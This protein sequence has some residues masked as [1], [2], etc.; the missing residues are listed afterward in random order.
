[1]NTESPYKPPEAD[2]S[3]G[4]SDSGDLMRAFIGTKNTDYYLDAFDKIES[5]AGRRWHWPAFFVTWFW[6]GYRKMWL[7]FFA[8]WII[9]PV[10]LSLAM[11]VL[12]LVH[13][14]LGLVGYVVGL[15][16]IPPLF[17]NQVY[18]N[19]A[20]NKLARAAASSSD[21][22]AQSQQAARLGGTSSVLLFV[23]LAIVLLGILAAIAIPAYQDYVL[24]AQ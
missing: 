16:F 11:V 5:G 21:P 18:Y 4:G 17:A 22:H 1:M 23:F 9:F 2:I 15:F 24:R 20:K 7:W 14:T 12:S 3:G 13:E 10:V 6:L 8:Y 19:H